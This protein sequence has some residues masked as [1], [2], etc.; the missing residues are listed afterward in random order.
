[1]WFIGDVHSRFKRYMHL[2]K[3]P[4]GGGA[5]MDCS[6]QLGDMG[7]GFPARYMLEASFP[8]SDEEALV[9]PAKVRETHAPVLS[10]AHRFIRGNH[11][12]PEMCRRHP[13]Y[14]GDCGYLHEL[15]MCFVS[16]GMSVDRDERRF[17]Y[18][19]WPNEE[20]APATLEEMVRQFGDLKP[21]IVASHEC[22]TDAK[23]H[24]VCNFAKIGIVSRTERALQRMFEAHQPEIWVFAHHHYYADVRVARTRFVGLNEL[25]LGPPEECVF[26]IPGLKW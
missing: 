2:I 18:D 15:E 7:V 4:P 21:R 23:H 12:H 6:L 26:E 25:I 13:C 20:L 19:W 16:G 3:A 22:P 5:G 17:G 24:A 10:A 11:D 14:L 9:A 8:A 1:M